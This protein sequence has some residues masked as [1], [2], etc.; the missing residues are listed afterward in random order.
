M[1][2]SSEITKRKNEKNGQTRPICSGKYFGPHTIWRHVLDSLQ[3][4]QRRIKNCH[5]YKS[6]LSEEV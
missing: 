1:C 2:Q 4:R 6:S 5:D 3:E